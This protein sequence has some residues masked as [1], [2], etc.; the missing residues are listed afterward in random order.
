MTEALHVFGINGKLLIAQA[1][2]FGLVLFVLWL[3]LYRP[4]MRI[5][6]ERQGKIR[7]GVEDAR[8][9]QV[10]RAGAEEEARTVMADVARKA[11]CALSDA[12]A[13]ASKEEEKIVRGAKEEEGRII[14]DATARAEEEKRKILSEG[15]EEIARM[16]VLGAEHILKEHE[17][18]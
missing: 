14:R 4:L 18:K 3:V 7:K 6:E 10:A 11:E 15:K 9:A 16:V 17:R 12:R 1:V 2:N 8:A 13:Q 5:L